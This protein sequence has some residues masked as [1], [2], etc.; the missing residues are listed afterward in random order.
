MTS[1][2]R[3]DGKT[4]IVT[5]GSR[6]LGLYAAEGLLEAGVTTLVITSRKANACDEAITY[7]K[8]KFPSANLNLISIPADLSKES[9]VKR[10]ISAVKA[11]GINKVHICLANAGA[12]WGAP[13]DSFPD[14]G[15][16]KVFDL[17]VRSVFNLIRE[18]AP[19]LEAAAVPGDPAR[20]ITVGSVAGIGIG[21]VGPNGTY[22]YA[23]SKA[24]VHHL[25]KHLAVALGPRGILVNAI[26]PGFF[27]TKMAAALINKSGGEDALGKSTPNG[28]L[29]GPQDIAGVVTFL[30]SKAASHVNGVVIPIDGGKHLLAGFDDANWKAKL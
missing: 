19:L 16:E 12:T 4:A 29:G 1:A 15:F 26:A 28:R 24:A 20:V 17:N 21:N 11:A 9:E 10:F 18:C 8:G 22:S 2:F 7:L 23:A 3:L 13:F 30:S 6:G 5:G 27:V 25:S 14:S